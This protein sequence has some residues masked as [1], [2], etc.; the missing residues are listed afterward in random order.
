[1]ISHDILEVLALCGVWEDYCILLGLDRGSNVYTR[2]NDVTS[3]LSNVNTEGCISCVML[4]GKSC[5]ILMWLYHTIM[6]GV[7]Y[8][9]RER[10]GDYWIHLNHNFIKWTLS[11][12]LKTDDAILLKVEYH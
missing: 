6:S 5:V 4:D 8:E 12:L 9:M 1:M 3:R 7:L 10:K 2:V 11:Q